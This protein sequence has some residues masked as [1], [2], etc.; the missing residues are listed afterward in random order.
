MT[1][2]RWNLTPSKRPERIR[3]AVI[4][5]A[6]V[7]DRLRPFTN[8]LPKCLVQVAGVPILDNTLSH[9]AALGTEEI[10]IV[11]GHH[12]EVII[13]RYGASY[14]GMSMTYVVSEEYRTTNNI[15]SLWLARSHLTQDV[16]LL[17]ADIFFEPA[18]LER[19]LS[20][21]SGNLVVPVKQSAL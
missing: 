11:V 16:L 20:Q 13:D 9:L 19:L 1:T 3:K 10:A 15:Y 12:K 6:G 2:D 14:L 21:S 5:A 18:V 8:K 17:E 4:L 7:G